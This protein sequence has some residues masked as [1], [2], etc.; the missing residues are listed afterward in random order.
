MDEAQ[1]T[2]ILSRSDNHLK[3]R[4]NYIAKLVKDERHWKKDKDGKSEMVISGRLDALISEMSLIADEMV[5][6][7]DKAND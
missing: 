7:E 1:K 3:E 4:L 2:W 5:K 6:R